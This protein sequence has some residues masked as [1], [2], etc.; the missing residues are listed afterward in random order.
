MN[1]RKY[2]FSK[3][4]FWPIFVAGYLQSRKRRERT[5]WFDK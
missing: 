4:N 1:Q 3:L 5:A 2:T